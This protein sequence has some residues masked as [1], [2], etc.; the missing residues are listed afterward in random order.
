MSES[1][2]IQKCVICQVDFLKNRRDKMCCSAKCSQKN[3]EKKYGIQPRNRRVDRP[4][5][6]CTICGSIFK[7]K[8][9]NA[10]SCSPKCSRENTLKK[11]GKYK[12]DYRHVD[13]IEKPCVVCKVE[14]K[15]RHIDAIYCSQKCRNRA[16]SARNRIMTVTWVKNTKE[17]KRIKANAGAKAQKYIKIET[18]CEACGT[19]EKLIRHHDD[20][21]KPLEVRIL[22]R[23]CHANWHHHNIPKI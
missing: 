7:P 21:S 16:T 18:P 1:H 19:T 13:H 11:Y 20:Y 15:P 12:R 9:K 10:L 14:F 3:S 23:T 2:T 8:R 17:Q 22:C 4:E 5:R 6:A